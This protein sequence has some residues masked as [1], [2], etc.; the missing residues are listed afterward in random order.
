M[1]RFQSLL[2]LVGLTILLPSTAMP[3]SITSCNPTFVA[4]VAGATYTVTTNLAPAAG[5]NCI[6]VTARNVTI[7]LNG[8]S[9]TGDYSGLGTGVYVFSDGANVTSSVAGG[10]IKGFGTG[11]NVD[12][13]HHG[14][15]AL[16]SVTITHINSIDNI[17]AGIHLYF[18]DSSPIAPVAYRCLIQTNEITANGRFG[19][20]LENT[21]GCAVLS[22]TISG[23]GNGPPVG[24][25]VW[26]QSS[27]RNKV[28]QNIA[29]GASIQFIGIWAGHDNYYTNE[30]CYTHDPSVHNSIFSNTANY[31]LDVGIGLERCS[32]L[33][34]TVT[35]NTATGSG[36]Y[37]LFDGNPVCDGNSWMGDTF[38]TANQSV[39][40]MCIH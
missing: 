17:G 37:D 26:L 33:G 21:N 23:N 19:V 7:D 29:D 16:H 15:P 18:V 3:I 39:N 13:G 22:N 35:L 2:G 5:A 34:N 27:S 40:P 6:E 32:A 8:H 24:I 14:H 4:S 9:L 12:N 36:T 31:N 10:T 1:Y 38:V 25:G 28:G 30:N 20:Y 11:V